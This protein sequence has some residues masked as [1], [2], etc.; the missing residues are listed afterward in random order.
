M[1][2]LSTSFFGSA[3]YSESLFLF[4]A[5]GAPYLARN[6]FW[7][8]AALLGVL[9][10]LSRFGGIIVAPMLLIEWWM[11]R[12]QRST[13]ARPL[14]GALLAGCAVPFGTGAYMLY[15]NYR[16]GDP[17]AFVHASAAWAR[18]PQSPLTC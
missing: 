17:L 14:L 12:R 5:I 16:F 9:A 2:I 13:E 6:G 18:E 7:E 8:S 10:T 1:L 15:L 3:I 4:T 11:Q